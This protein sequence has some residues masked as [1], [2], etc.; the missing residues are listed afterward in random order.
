MIDP[1][2]LISFHP[3]S[4]LHN[5]LSCPFPGAECGLTALPGVKVI[6]GPENV[7]IGGIQG[8]QII[9]DTPILH[10]ILWLKDD[11]TWLGGGETGFEQASRR[12]MILLN[13][14]GEHYLLKFD[15]DPTTFDAH[16]PLVQ[17][18]FNSIKFGK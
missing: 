8:S 17:E 10:P 6:Q 16:Y 7:T 5:S 3:P 1:V 11:F 13:V 15:D 9:M 12:Y 18:I 14:H 4:L 2:R